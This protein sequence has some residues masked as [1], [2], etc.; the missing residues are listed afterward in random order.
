MSHYIPKLGI[1]AEQFVPGGP[2]GNNLHPTVTRIVYR[3]SAPF[4]HEKYFANRKVAISY[5]KKLV[6]QGS[7]HEVMVSQ[8]V[9]RIG[10]RPAVV[11]LLNQKQFVLVEQHIAAYQDGEWWES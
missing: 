3:V 7:P 11:N 6:R 4:G 1:T 9:V 10:G 8:L 5:A 2:S